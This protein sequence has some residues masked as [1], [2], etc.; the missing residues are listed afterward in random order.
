MDDKTC[1]ECGDVFNDPEQVRR[2]LRKHGMT[3]QQYALRWVY[4]NV[5]P[6][7]KCGCGQ[8]IAWNVAIKGYAMFVLGH[9]AWGRR[10]SD[11]EKRRIGE[12]N[13]TNMKR[14]MRDHPDVVQSKIEQMRSGRT[15]EVYARISQSI[16]RFWSSG[17]ELSKQRRKETSDRAIVLLEQN[18]IGP[19]AP[20]KAQWHDNPFTGKAEYMHSSWETAFLQRCID[21]GYPV[22]KDHG[23]RIAYVQADDTENQYVPDFKAL[24][25]NVLFEIK[26][27]MTENDERKLH[28]AQVRGYEVVM[29]DYLST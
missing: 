6:D 19:Q 24:E 5:V 2:H 22:T 26:G 15:P 9:H 11:D 25:E 10:K 7:C 29:I 23:I 12:K 20:Y 13:A 14:Y 3:F 28:A 18:K 4:N 17:S 27:L 16:H 8:K 1:K 21:E